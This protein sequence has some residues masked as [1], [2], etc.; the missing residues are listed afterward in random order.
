MIIDVFDSYAAAKRA[1]SAFIN[2]A[3]RHPGLC[4]VEYRI[5]TYYSK[6]AIYRGRKH[7]DFPDDRGYIF[8]DRVR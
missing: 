5:Y 3:E 6:Y 2:G 4:G 7:S 1:L 8:A